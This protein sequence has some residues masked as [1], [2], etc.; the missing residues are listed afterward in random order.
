[1]QNGQCKQALGRAIWNFINLEETV[2]AILAESGT[3]PSE[4]QKPKKAG[5]QKSPSTPSQS[6]I[7]VNPFEFVRSKMAGEKVLLLKGMIAE[8][9]ARG[10]PSDVVDAIQKG[11]EAFNEATCKHRNALA[12]A[13]P[14]TAGY[15][16]KIFQPG[17]AYSPDKNGPKHY[18]SE[19][20]E[21]RELA[22]RIEDAISPL[23]DARTAVKNYV[24]SI[25][26]PA[27]AP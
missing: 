13:Q 20:A 16:E 23:R 11:Y 2:T 18:A 17:I 5:T 27:Q 24:A 12:H 9:T 6:P 19:A 25:T 21:I 26:G 4:Y 1:M 7:S 22:H 3:H 8:W 14:F 10:V 15:V